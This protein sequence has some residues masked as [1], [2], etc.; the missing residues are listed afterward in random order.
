M[1]R[2]PGLGYKYYQEHKNEIWKKGYIQLDNGKRASIPRYFQEMQRIEDPRVLWELKQRNQQRAI[3]KT[4]DMLGRTDV[5][6]E[7]YLK[8]KEQAVK[9]H[10]KLWAKSNLVSVR[11]VPNKAGTWRT[12][13]YYI[14]C[15]RSSRACGKVENN[16]FTT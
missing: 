12:S 5:P 11:Q 7:D 15:S 16:N 9:N 8:A 14:C 10:E 1:S 6:Y 2:D 13:L 3:D 4:K